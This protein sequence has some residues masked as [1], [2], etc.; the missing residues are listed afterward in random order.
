MARS[1]DEQ[2]LHDW[3]IRKA[4]EKYSRLFSDVHINPG[5]EKNFDH[6]GKYPDLVIMNYGQ[7]VQIV[8]VETKETINA[9]RVPKWK[10]M[11][12]LG[13]KLS[14]LV[15]KETQGAVRDICW[16]NGLAA[17]V[18]IGSFEVVLNI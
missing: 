17:K 4:Q 15:P 14:L 16:K 11:S 1:T 2:F 3:V 10:D 7:V 6:K 8:E 12:E 13:V 9:G 18:N 5:N